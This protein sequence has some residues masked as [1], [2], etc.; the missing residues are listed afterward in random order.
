MSKT[1]GLRNLRTPVASLVLRAA[2]ALLLICSV[3]TVSSAQLDDVVRPD[4]PSSYVVKEGDTLWGISGMFLSQPWMW[5]ELWRANPEIANPHLIYPGDTIRLTYVDGM[6]R[7]TLERGDD[8]RTTRLSPSSTVKLEPQI[9]SEPL[10]SNIPTISI[11]ALYPFL[12][13]NRIV[14]DA[15]LNDAPYVIPGEGDRFYARGEFGG[16]G[17]G[18]SIVR[19]NQVYT[20]PDDGRMLGI[21]AIEIGTARVINSAGDVAT[22]EVIESKQSVN[23]GDRLLPVQERSTHAEGHRLFSSATRGA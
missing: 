15:E 12:S 14:T 23:V 17:S 22:L 5:P 8:G 13:S 7:L 20:D 10:L 9:R 19:R 11:A 16:V 4:A 3:Q 21:E 18:V 6:P 1:I 2:A